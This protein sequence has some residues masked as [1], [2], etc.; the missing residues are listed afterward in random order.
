MMEGSNTRRQ[1]QGRELMPFE[2][3]DKDL[4]V[5]LSMKY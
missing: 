1:T 2:D 3:Q 5:R 4:Q